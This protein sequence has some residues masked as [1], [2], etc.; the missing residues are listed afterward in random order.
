MV[1]PG[2]ED[3]TAR[4]NVEKAISDY[5]GI[6]EIPSS[7]VKDNGLGLHRRRMELG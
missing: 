2:S 1:S 6:L 4:F 5:Y 3:L 7:V